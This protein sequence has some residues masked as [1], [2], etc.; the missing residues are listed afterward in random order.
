MHALKKIV[1]PKPR[2]YSDEAHTHTLRQSSLDAHLHWL[3]M[4]ILMFPVQYANV[5][6]KQR[7]EVKAIPYTYHR[8]LV[9]PFTQPKTIGNGRL[10]FRAHYRPKKKNH[11][12]TLPRLPVVHSAVA[13]RTGHLIARVVGLQHFRGRACCDTEASSPRSRSCPRQDEGLGDL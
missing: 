10:T 12:L 11:L 8:Q 7:P 6:S 1:A 4:S 5:Q 3:Q 13:Y 2:R 9:Q